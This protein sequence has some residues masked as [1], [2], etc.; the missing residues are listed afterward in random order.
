[1]RHYRRSSTSIVTRAGLVLIVLCTF[2]T[3]LAYYASDPDP[4]TG[5]WVYGAMAHNIISGGH[6]F[7]VNANAGSEFSFNTPMPVRELRGKQGLLVAPAEANLKYADAHPRWEPFN[8]EPVGEAVLLAG[9]WEI[10]GSQT[11][12]PDVLMKT[13]LDALAA[14]LVY[15]V[16]MLLYRRRRA[17]L[18]A[19]LFYALYPPIAYIVVNPNRDIWS[20]DFTIAVLAGFVEAT[21]SRHPRRWLVAC[22]VLVGIGAYFDPNALLLP[23]AMAFASVTVTGW[24]TALHR[25]LIPTMIAAL[26]LTPWIIRNYN[27][28]HTFV[29][30]RTGLG[31]AMW[32]GLSEIQ[33]SYGPTSY[34]YVSYLQV[35]RVRPDIHWGTPAYDSVLVNKTIALIERHP[36]FYL[37]T[38]AHRIWISTIGELEMGWMRRGTTIPS[39]YP[40]GRL[41]YV[42]EQP[43][44]L[45][46]VTL[47]PLIFLAAM[48]ALGLT[49]VRYKREHLLLI[50]V[51][52]A[53]GLP[54]LIVNTEARYIMP[55]S[56]VLLIW[57]AVGGDLLVERAYAWRRAKKRQIPVHPVDGQT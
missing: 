46:Q 5:P 47:M 57:I 12:L 13:V 51:A 31:Q 22:G 4:R 14:L 26:M 34:D 39:A 17:A 2:G 33:N 43:F 23:G 1:M 48:A 8:A 24:R 36:L 7:Q 54:Y 20:L 55:I 42:I 27:A 41:A 53:V 50:A 9:V 38:I 44:Q 28:Y 19:G 3:R 32:E 35:H 25:A 10:T 30:T 29:P 37:N 6:W 16:V 21:N 15:R 18:A 45:I 49:W 52:M 11:Y 56:I 40:R